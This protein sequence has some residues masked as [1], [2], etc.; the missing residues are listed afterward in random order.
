MGEEK[1]G[2]YVTGLQ[3]QRISTDQCLIC[4]SLFKMAMHSSETLSGSPILVC[5][6]L[7]TGEQAMM[8]ETQHV[9]VACDI[10]IICSITV[11][12]QVSHAF[13]AEARRREFC[14]CFYKLGRA[15]RL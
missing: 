4:L 12:T 15:G 13:Q 1:E 3:E 2:K 10:T 8:V 14:K 6:A 11:H 7:E 9:V 5:K